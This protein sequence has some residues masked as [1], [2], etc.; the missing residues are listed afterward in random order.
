MDENGVKV[1]MQVEMEHLEQKIGYKFKDKLLFKRALTHTSYA[2]EQKINKN[3]H[4]ERLEFLGDAVLELVTSE[5]LFVNNPDMEEG[6][7]TKM[8]AAI[9]CEVSLAKSAND[10]SLSD[11]IF[12]GKGES[13]TGGR[14]RESIIADVMEAVIGAIYLDGGID[15]AKVFVQKFILKDLEER[16]W[17]YDAKSS[18]Q[19]K[20]QQSKLG[21][22]SYIL[23]AEIGPEH[24]K[25]FECAVNVGGIQMG[26]GR[27]KSKKEAE[28]RAALEALRFLK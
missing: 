20:V 23:L 26:K 28:Q 5:Y 18:L 19:E 27:G 10:I 8:R 9:V 17:F 1:E 24:Q 15:A 2:N 16:K 7:M 11:Y 25:E 12:L 3:G 4:Y 22:I 13:S 21:I 14:K 6:A